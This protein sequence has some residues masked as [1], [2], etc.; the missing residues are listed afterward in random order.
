MYL[1]TVKSKVE[2]SQN[3]VAFLEYMNFNSIVYQCPVSSVVVN[4]LAFHTGNQNSILCIDKLI[5]KLLS[6]S[7]GHPT[8]IFKISNL[9]RFRGESYKS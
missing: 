7:R 1:V 6:S 9:Q 3:S 2:I 4:T 8:F 5:L